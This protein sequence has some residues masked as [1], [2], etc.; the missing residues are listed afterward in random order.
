MLFGSVINLRLD[1]EIVL[2]SQTVKGLWFAVNLDLTPEGLALN[3]P[4][5]QFSFRQASYLKQI[6]TQ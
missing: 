3:N 4:L 1:G 5:G 6:L 2:I